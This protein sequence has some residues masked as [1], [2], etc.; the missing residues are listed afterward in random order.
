MRLLFCLFLNLLVLF[1]FSQKN[2]TTFGIQIKPIVPSELFGTGPITLIEEDVEFTLTPTLG[3]NFGMLIRKGLNDNW[4]IETGIALVRRNYRLEAFDT[5][6][7]IQVE[8]KYRFVS[9]EIPVQALYYIRLGESFYMNAA[10]GISLDFY[11]SNIYS[12]TFGDRDTLGYQIEQST[13][14]VHWAQFSLISNLGFEYRTKDKGYFYLGASF[15]QQFV[16]DMA[17]VGMTYTL[18]RGKTST[19]TSIQSNYLTLDLRYF[20]NEKPEKRKR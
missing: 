3:T 15:H 10:A 2:I 6:N 1:S 4:S 13:N 11:P 12:N 5:N 14:R 7:D 20:F 19:N 16:R 18:E 9:Y 8:S 17:Y